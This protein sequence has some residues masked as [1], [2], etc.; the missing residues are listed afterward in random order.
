M[1]F[2][3]CCLLCNSFADG[4]MYIL[5]LGMSGEM[6]NSEG[7]K[8]SGDTSVPPEVQISLTT[9]YFSILYAYMDMIA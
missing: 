9:V 4:D 3:C 2:L 8:P 6:V 5:P 7:Q 1:D